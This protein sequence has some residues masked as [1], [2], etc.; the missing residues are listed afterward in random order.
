MNTNIIAGEPVKPIP[1]HTLTTDA[2][3]KELNVDAQLGLN[4]D[5]ATAR[6]DT[7]G[8]NELIER[9]KKHPLMLLLEQFGSMLVII[10][11]VAA[12]ISGFLGKPTET[13]AILAIVFLFAILGFVQEYRAEKAMAA[14]KK[15]T[16]PIVRVRRNGELLEI[17]AR[18]LVPGDIIILEAGNLVPADARLIDCVNLKIQE[19]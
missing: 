12:V 9:R 10:L 18:D 15:L 2:A 14:L 16:V 3:L 4:H 13:I 17:S 7:Y 5:E 8:P 11:I 19:A 1:W 6:L